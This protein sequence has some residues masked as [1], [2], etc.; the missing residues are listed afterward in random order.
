MITLGKMSRVHL[1]TC[2]PKIQRLISEL[3]RRVPRPMDFTIT[4]GHRG[5]AEQDAAYE[6]GRS[7]KTWP[8]SLHNRLPSPA[9]DLAPYPVDWKDVP[10]FARLAGYVQCVADDLGIRIR[11]GGD[12]DQDGRTTDEKLVDIPHFE[13]HSEE[14]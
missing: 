5:Q 14:F 6:D 9:V 1:E 2:H 13:L 10:R 4:C 7:T 11:W 8:N 3:A 12:W